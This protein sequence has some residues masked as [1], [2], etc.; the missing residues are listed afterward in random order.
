MEKVS[1]VWG[2][3]EIICNHDYCGKKLVLEKNGFCSMH[4]HKNKDETF[5]I[6]K[7]KIRLETYLSDKKDGFK[8]Q[9]LEVGEYVR[10]LPFVPHRFVGLED[11]EIIEFSTHHEDEDSYRL[12]GMLSGR[13]EVEKNE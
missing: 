8:E 6:I 13:I 10:I 3:E 4:Y 12:E 7:G 11:S 1:K 9:I 2:H 5:Y